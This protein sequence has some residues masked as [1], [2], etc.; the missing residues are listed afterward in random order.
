MNRLTDEE[1][2]DTL[3]ASRMVGYF[4]P[5]CMSPYMPEGPSIR[6]P[7][8]LVPSDGMSDRSHDG[9]SGDAASNTGG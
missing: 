1:R 9:K 6:E 7:M 8:T 5:D 2:G 3:Y 4:S